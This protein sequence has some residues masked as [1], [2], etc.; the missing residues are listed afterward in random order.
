MSQAKK[1]TSL[2][3]GKV[4]ASNI[5]GGEDHPNKA[6]L[7]HLDR[8]FLGLGPSVLR[9]VFPDPSIVECRPE[10]VHDMEIELR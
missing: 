2:R 7:S 3:A 4:R 10:V 1:S 9:S 6:I 8:A 5:D